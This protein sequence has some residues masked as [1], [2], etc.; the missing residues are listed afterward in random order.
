[1][2]IVH[3]HHET[4]EGYDWTKVYFRSTAARREDY[5]SGPPTTTSVRTTA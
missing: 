1:V 4:F 2:H 3:E 5:L